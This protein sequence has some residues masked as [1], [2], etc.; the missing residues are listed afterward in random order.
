MVQLGHT[1]ELF[2]SKQGDF[3]MFQFGYS[4][5]CRPLYGGFQMVN[6]VTQKTCRPPEGEGSF[7]K[8]QL[9]YLEELSVS[10]QVVFQMVKLGS[11]EDLSASRQ[12]VF[13]MVSWVTQRTC[14]L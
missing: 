10:G 1:E 11:T 8:V 12:G 9:D 6:W 2:A 4:N 7:K 5:T 14:L 13:Q 3:Q